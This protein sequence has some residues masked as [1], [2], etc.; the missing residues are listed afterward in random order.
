MNETTGQ[1]PDSGKGHGFPMRVALMTPGGDMQTLWLPAKA[2]GMYRFQPGPDAANPSLLQLRAEGGGWCAV[3]GSG[4]FFFAYDQGMGGYAVERRIGSS[5]ELADRALYHIR[6]GESV[7]VLYTEA[8][9]EESNVF[10]HYYIEKSYP[11]RIGRS[12]DCDICYSNRLV[13]REHASLRWDGRTWVIRDLN[14]RN[15]VYLNGKMVRE[16]PVGVGDVIYIMGLRVLM[17]VGFISLNDGNNRVRITSPRLR[18]IRQETDA[19]FSRSTIRP[20]TEEL[21]KRQPRHRLPL[22]IEPIE[23]E[24]PPMKLG[25]NNIPL[26]LRMGS[27]AVM[28][29]RAIMSGNIAMALTSMV[30]PLL[31]NGYSEKDR[32]DYENRRREKYREYLKKKE[33]QIQAE[34]YRELDVLSR[35]YPD[36][37]Q[38]LQILDSRE[39]LW[40]RKKIDDDFLK[41]RI[42]HGRLP[43]LAQREYE[44][45]KFGIEEDELEDEMYALAEKPFF[46]ENA[47]ILL[48]LVE[49]RLVAVGGNREQSLIFL[50]ML[51]TRLVL[52]HSYDEVKLVA[53]MGLER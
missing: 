20:R 50:Q 18:R 22:V 38:I 21:F 35:T 10:H 43:M 5:V 25:G 42:G 27:P 37:P 46:L 6:Y 39:R 26:L 4:A 44:P 33:Q 47:P 23:I 49:D 40:E 1:Y 9:N 48:S 15:G 28:G 7:F 41:I 17:G 34:Q 53:D 13:S 32:K 31:T 3:L 36:F 19:E 29:G 45:R 24:M 11:I 8:E 51:L 16:A 30:F 12:P 52:L 14:S 2:E